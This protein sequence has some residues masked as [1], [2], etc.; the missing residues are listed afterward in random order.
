MNLDNFNNRISNFFLSNCNE[1]IC[2]TCPLYF[3][4]SVKQFL[5]VSIPSY[6]INGR[7]KRIMQMKK[8]LIFFPTFVMFCMNGSSVFPRVRLPAANPF[9]T[10]FRLSKNVE[11]FSSPLHSSPQSPL[12]RVLE[13]RPPP[14][15][16]EMA[17]WTLWTNLHSM[18]RVQ[19]R[20]WTCEVDSIW[21][22]FIGMWASCWPVSMSKETQ[23][24]LTLPLATF[25]FFARTAS[26]SFATWSKAKCF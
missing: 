16:I 23:S 14:K 5:L 8:T 22:S 4:K 10:E 25:S 6:I 26:R 20:I 19:K 9:W 13:S 2:S 17:R 12:E 3:M 21:K 1:S 18:M 11:S 24:S 7:L 15:W